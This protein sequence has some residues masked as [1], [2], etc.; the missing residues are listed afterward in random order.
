MSLFFPLHRLR[1]NM[2][3]TPSRCREYRQT[4]KA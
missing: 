1:L 4:L 3:F 2:L